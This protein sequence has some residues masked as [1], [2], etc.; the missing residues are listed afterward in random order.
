MRR[1]RA[2]VLLAPLVLVAACDSGTDDGLP[3]SARIVQVTVNDAP[4]FD[5]VSGDDWDDGTFGG[6]GPDIY[7]ALFDDAVDYVDGREGSRL[8]A[9]DD[10]DVVE[11]RG[12]TDDVDARDFPL[13]WDV[14]GFRVD[15]LSDRL[16]VALYDRDGGLAGDDD[17][18][19]ESDPFTLRT[20]APA[21]TDGRVVTFDLDGFD[22]SGADADVEIRVSVIY[23]AE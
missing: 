17:P 19:V 22:L 16:Y 9:R 1:L 10:G 12:S 23:D 2:L 5:P 3:V 6:S 14:E 11:A 20:S 4:L 18:M 8:N 21:I 13:V 7:F 15:D